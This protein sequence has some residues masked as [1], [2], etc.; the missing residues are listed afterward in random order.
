MRDRRLAPNQALDS[1]SEGKPNALGEAF[2]LDAKQLDSLESTFTGREIQFDRDP[3]GIENK[4]L[5]KV[6]TRHG[7]L[8]EAYA[9][10]L[11]TC[12]Y[13]G[14]ILNEERDVVEGA[15]PFRRGAVAKI[16]AKTAGRA[17]IDADQVDY[18]KI[19][20]VFTDIE[21]VSGEVERRAVAL[22]QAKDLGIKPMG[23]CKIFRP[24]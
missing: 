14:P 10:R 11:A 17:G 21:P 8:F 15:G 12:V 9:P 2:W 18:A 22:P 20:F 3:G 24:Y 7:A 23:G 6:Q 13:L 1:R 16:F 4:D 5:V 19:A